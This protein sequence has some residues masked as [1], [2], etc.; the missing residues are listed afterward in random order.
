[1]LCMKNRVIISKPRYDN[2]DSNGPLVK[3]KQKWRQS[4]VSTGC[5]ISSHCRAVRP[6]DIQRTGCLITTSPIN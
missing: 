3:S 6:F 5:S 4:P 1:M 2:I